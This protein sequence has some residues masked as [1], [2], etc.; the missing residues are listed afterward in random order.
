MRPLVLSRKFGRKLLDS[1]NSFTL[2]V[3][4]EAGSANLLLSYF[5]KI[6][7]NVKVWAEGVASEITTNYRFELIKSEELRN[8]KTDIDE[9]YLAGTVEDQFNQ[10]SM[11]E[12]IYRESTF[13]KFYVFDNWVNYAQRFKNSK[14][15]N[16][17]V[18]DRFAR[19]LVFETF[20]PDINVETKPNLYLRKIREEMEQVGEQSQEIIL[21]LGNKV[22][23]FTSYSPGPHGLEC[24]CNAIELVLLKFPQI[25]I[26][27]RP[28]P[29]SGI[30]DCAY[31]LATTCDYFQ[32]S[33]ASL[34]REL[35]RSK[36]VIGNPTY[37][38]YIAS[39][40]GIPVA[41]LNPANEFWG[42]PT[43]P[44]YHVMLN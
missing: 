44:E 31:Y 39:E 27:F 16:A 21:L 37:A 43:F 32:I 26:V 6:D 8:F 34:A 15:E 36:L 30:G 17:I 13:K 23:N 7:R 33:S 4:C 2:L 11:V 28:H 12:E 29:G 24:F 25:P 9:L 14:I 22:N 3:V 5:E 20:G 35:S 42:G 41:F 18:F 40:L 19:D 10:I 38:L 1:K